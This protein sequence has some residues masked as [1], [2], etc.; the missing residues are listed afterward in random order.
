[1]SSAPE[2]AEVVVADEADLRAAPDLLDHLVR[3]RP[4]ADE[5]TEAPDLVR[6]VGV[7]RLEDGLERV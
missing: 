6:R 5:V 7:D 4:V 1:M 3:P 2:D